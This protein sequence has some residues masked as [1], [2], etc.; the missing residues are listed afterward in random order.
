MRTGGTVRERFQPFQRERQVCAAFVVGDRVDFIDDHG[1]DI[2]QNGAALL[3]P[4]AECR[5]TP[6]W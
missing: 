6:A 4:S 3:A 2:A 5:A 1:F